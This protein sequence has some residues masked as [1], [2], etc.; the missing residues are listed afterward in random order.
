MNIE[1]KR[2]VVRQGFTLHKG[3]AIF[4]AGDIVSLSEFQARERQHQIEPVVEVQAATWEVENAAE[5]PGA[6][7]KKKLFAR[8]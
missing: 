2:Y 7:P 5:E 3:D 6:K 4:H 1:E 8:N